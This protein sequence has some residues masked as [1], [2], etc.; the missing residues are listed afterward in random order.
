NLLDDDRYSYWATDDEVTS[1]ELAITL[2]A[3]ATFDLIRLR[4]NIKLGQRLDSVWVDVWEDEAW[5]PLAMATS[6]GSSRIIPLEKPV[7]AQRLRLRLFAPVAVTL[8]DFGLFKEAD[9][10]YTS[11]GTER[12]AVDPTAWQIVDNGFVGGDPLLAIDKRKETHWLTDEVQLPQHITIDMGQLQAI[13]GFSYLPRQD[14][15]PTG[16]VSR[17]T[18]A[19]SSDGTTWNAVVNGEFSNIVNNPIAQYVYFDNEVQARYFRFTVEAVANATGNRAKVG[20]AEFEIYR[21]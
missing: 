14:G 19:T 6:I 9:V 17:Y 16:H 12:R 1:P 18:F 15:E 7:T 3:A 11:G 8:S 5:R 2:K 13:N 21:N 10:E 4:E 20:M